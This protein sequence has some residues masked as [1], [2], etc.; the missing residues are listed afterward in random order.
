MTSLR[1]R[2]LVADDDE[3]IRFLWNNALLRPADTYEVVTVC[4]GYQALEA[5]GRMPFDLV[6]TDIWMPGMGGVELTEA[7]RRLGYQGP[8]VWITAH[9]LSHLQEDAKQLDVYRSLDKPV[10]V[11]QM[12]QVVADA[13]ATGRK[14]GR[15]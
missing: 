4:D 3:G 14:E 6:I 10:R 7:I 12:R 8:I 9:G 11:A 5:I 15:T 2:I 1:H 13:L